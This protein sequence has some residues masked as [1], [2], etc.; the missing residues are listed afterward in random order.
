MIEQVCAT[1]FILTVA[2]V[3]VMQ[4]VWFLAGKR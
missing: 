4:L 1:L 2:I 3:L